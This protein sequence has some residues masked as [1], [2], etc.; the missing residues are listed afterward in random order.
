MNESTQPRI[1][2]A[3]LVPVYRAEDGELRLVLIRR[4]EAGFH[5]G[6]LAF[7]GGKH[8]PGDRSM[9][10]TA[11][12]EAWEEIGLARETVEVLAELP[13]MDTRTA[14]F[15]IYPF[16]GRIVRPSAWRRSER[17]VAEVVEVALGELARS[18][19]RGDDITLSPS[20]REPQRGPFYRVGPYQLW[21][22]TYR[23]LH[24]LLPRLL[25]REWEI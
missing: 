12:R 3:V 20:W 7:P 8:D 9:S 25:G 2:S 10:D 19:N 24:P 6:Q 1:D 13:A 4:T 22:A 21:G 18:E 14:A 15:R 5:G 17:E 23:I 11:L 16:L